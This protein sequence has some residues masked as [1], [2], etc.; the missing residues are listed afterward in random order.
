MNSENKKEWADPY[1]GLNDQQRKVVAWNIGKV[2]VSATPG[3]GKTRSMVNRIARMVRDG[4]DPEKILATTFTKKAAGEM[5]ERLKSLGCPIKSNGDKGARVGTF[6]SVCLEIIHDGSPW[7]S[8]A[9]DANDQMRFALKV[10]VGFQGMRWEGVDLTKVESF[11]SGCKN[12]LI[13]P[14]NCKS[15]RVGEFVSSRYEE[16]YFRYEEE[17]E[18]KGLITFDDMLYLAVRYLQSDQDALL[19][20]SGRYD[21]IMVDEGQDSN[22]A[23]HELVK[24]L[25][26]NATSVMQVADPDQSIYRFR[27]AHPELIIEASKSEGTTTIKMEINY[28]SQPE[29]I[30]AANKLI[31]NNQN[32]IET[33]AVANKT[34]NGQNVIEF[35]TTSDMDSEAASVLERILALKED[36]YAWKDFFVLIRTNAQSRAFEEVFMAAKIPFVIVGGTDFWNRKEVADL[37]SYVKVAATGDDTACL[38]SLNRPF[39]FIG[40]VTLELLATNAHRAKKSIIDYLTSLD[41]YT[42][43]SALQIQRRQ[44]E[45][46]HNYVRIISNVRGYLNDEGMGLAE[47]IRLVEKETGYEAWL[48]KDEGSDSPENSRVSN[49]K[50][51]V[52]TVNRFKT[53][54]ELFDYL[55]T[56]KAA[57]K[58]KKDEGA[59]AIQVMSCHRG[60]GLE[61]PVVFLAGACAG[62]IPHHRSDDIEEERR[63]FYVA[64]TRAKDRLFVSSPLS[65]FV[66]AS[67]KDMA[68]SQ[69]VFEAGLTENR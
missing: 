55:D 38:R 31:K 17:R 43:A 65:A 16:A 36:G 44:A 4:V 2:V 53:A 7:R 68:I 35:F 41:H 51:L 60:K 19:R 29:I 6:H 40:K 22:L 50:E 62:I 52:R 42:M 49:I 59:D 54:K 57:K 27:G 25:S 33:Q 67:L 5:N 14:E 20:W 8:Y 11:I 26:L 61:S 47:V 63:L 69:F 1:E 10:L 56:M 13:D 46:I 9:V 58:A 3:S 28:R 32:R 15:K 18:K 39:R 12:D 23:Q 30:S 37:L 48:L 21:H 34:S 64:I 66:G 24:L 45:S